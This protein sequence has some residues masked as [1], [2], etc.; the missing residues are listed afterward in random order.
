MIL[1]SSVV[2]FQALEPLQPRWP[3]RPLQPQ[4]PLQPQKPFFTKE[5]PDSG[6]WIIPGTKM[7]NT[8]PFLL[9]ESSKIQIFTDN[10]YSIYQRLLRPA[11]VIFLKTKKICQKFIISGSQNYFQTRFYLHISI[12]QS[13][14]IKHSSIWDTLYIGWHRDYHL[15]TYQRWHVIIFFLYMDMKNLVLLQSPSRF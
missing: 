3:Q 14:F 2:P 11:D 8:V 5:L 1:K 10:L 6:G 12:C 9:N 13:Q 15:P 7:T 4:Q